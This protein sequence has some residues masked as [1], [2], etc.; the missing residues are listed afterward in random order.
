M[1][2]HGKRHETGNESYD[3]TFSCIGDMHAL[4]QG[5]KAMAVSEGVIE[6]KYGSRYPQTHPYAVADQHWIEKIEKETN[7]RVKIKPYWAE[8]L[9]TYKDSIDGVAKGTVDIGSITLFETGLDLTKALIGY[10]WGSPSDKLNI[11]IYWE[12][13]DKFPELRKEFERVKLLGCTAGYALAPDDDQARENACRSER[14]EDKD[15]V[16]YDCPSEG[17]WCG[18]S[19]DTHERGL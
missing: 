5:M 4:M 13:W 8:T 9:L 2:Y 17:V 15:N 10:F 16:R 1:R 19:G 14:D 12:L 3:N 7:G 6:L 11:K 18:R